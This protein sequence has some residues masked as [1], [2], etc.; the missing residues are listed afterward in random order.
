MT[1]VVT[2]ANLSVTKTDGETCV[3]AGCGDGAYL[4]DHREQRGSVDCEAVCL[5]DVW[6]AG[7]TQGT[8]TP[9]Q[10][11][12]CTGAPSFTCALGTIN[13][14]S[15]ATV[16][17]TYTVPAGTTVARRTPRADERGDRPAAGQQLGD[18]HR[19]GDDR[20]GSVGGQ[21][22]AGGGDRGW[23][24]RV[25]LHDHGDQQRPVRQCGWVHGDRH[26]AG[27]CGVRARWGPAWSAWSWRGR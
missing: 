1:T 2:S 18:G 4:H 5:S 10:G 19:H 12:A 25:R 13:S 3:I 11:P 6:P 15:F 14:G 26:A 9:S 27:R 7:F 17:V 23:F 20:R 16:S 21:G 22:G 8:I 24:G